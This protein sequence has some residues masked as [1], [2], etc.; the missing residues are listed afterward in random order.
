MVENNLPRLRQLL[1]KTAAVAFLL[2]VLLLIAVPAHAADCPCS[3][4]PTTV[5]PSAITVEDTQ[6]VELG[7]KFTADSSG[8]ITAVRFYKNPQNK[9]THTGSLWDSAGN[10]LATATFMD[11]SASGWQQADFDAPVAISAGATYIAS[12]FAPEGRYSATYGGLK[13]AV[14]N[15]PLHTLASST[16]GGNGVFKYGGGFPTVTF[17]SANY[18]VDVVFASSVVSDTTPPTVSTILPRPGNNEVSAAA[19]VTV[20][21]SEP[22]NPTTVNNATFELRNSAN[23][24]VPATVTYSDTPHVV[25]HVTVPATGQ[26]Q[27]LAGIAK[28]VLATILPKYRQTVSLDPTVSIATLNPVKDL[29]AGSYTATIRGGTAGPRIKDMAGNAMVA[30]I[31]WSFTTVAAPVLDQGPG[32]PILIIKNDARPFSKY[33][34]EILRAEGLNSFATA[35]L[36]TV[37]PTMLKQYTVVLLGEMT[38]TDAQVAM[39]TDWVNAGGNLIAM[40][41]DKKLAGLL[42]LTDQHATLS[43]GYMLVNTAAAPGA[44][45][46]GQTIQYH[47][48]ADKYALDTGTESV[49]MLYST[50]TNAT[51]NPAVSIRSVGSNGGQAAAFTYNLAKSIIYTRQGNP[52]WAGQERDGD[53]YNL[54]RPNDL[55]Y[56]AKIGDVQPDYVNL[57]KVAIPQ[58]D[59]QQRLLA[60]MIN[61]MNQDKMPL[62]KFWYFPKGTKAVVVMTGDDHATPSG[63]RD[64]FDRLIAA[65]PAGCNVAEWECARATSWMYVESPMTNA[66]AARYHAQGFDIGSHVNTG[67]SN[68]TAASLD[69]FFVTAI[70]AFKAKYTS[71]PAQHGQR[72]H[73]IAWSDWAT[74]PKVELSHNHR[75]DLNYYYWPDSWVQDR[76]GFFTG[77][78]LP[79]RFGDLDGS[80]IDVYQLPSHLVNESGQT[81][82]ANINMQLDRALGEEGYYGALGTHYDYSDSFDQQLIQSAQERN[83]PLVS[84]QQLLDWTDAR[85]SSSFTGIAWNGSTLEFT[86]MVDARAG[87][88]MRSLL[89]LESRKGRLASLTRE[90]APVS[91]ITETIKGVA[92]AVFPT[93]SGA[94]AAAYSPD[95]DSPP[96]ASPPGKVDDGE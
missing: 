3:I 40:K 1:A 18:W 43:E 48:P 55:F 88:M 86:A 14:H 95:A 30:N 80:M 19:N 70:H 77:S 49:A 63:T 90:G 31:V 9:G 58:A 85:N 29:P 54:I 52:A 62:P 68:W 11:E 94:Y 38:I 6:P 12:Y 37:T 7:V 57:D 8:V 51:T 91:Y 10:R 64:T 26:N 33:Y 66:E 72:I 4:W 83:V 67:C 61:F 21:F 35:S 44:G 41:P 69:K 45:I 73:C 92:Y 22:L 23:K 59:E 15:A 81:F 39:L 24:L 28:K 89:P 25:R 47:G 76:P 17:S 50:A 16:P 36:S 74:A 75:I 46:V 84:A 42:G 65:S 56:G 32:G 71:L 87:S 53:S 82:P 34:A 5:T 20:A 79:M 2:P 13:E 27:T 93:T 96:A 60:N 78:G